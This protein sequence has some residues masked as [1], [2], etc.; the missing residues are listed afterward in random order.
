MIAFDQLRQDIQQR[1]RILT[2]LECAP[3][4]LCSQVGLGTGQKDSSTKQF[5]D[6]SP[7]V[8][9]TR[10]DTPLPV[11]AYCQQVNIYLS[12]IS[13]SHRFAVFLYI[14]LL[15]LR[16]VA[17]GTHN[18]VYVRFRISVGDTPE[19][20][21]DT[22]V[23]PPPSMRRGTNLG[24][25]SLHKARNLNDENFTLCRVAHSGPRCKNPVAKH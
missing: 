19:V 10:E 12:H 24:I 5:S 4:C 2:D 21:R 15:V 22:R 25:V 9:L 13:I 8:V 18:R 11:H 3:I 20:L 17:R 1:C 23:P 14:Q 6:L 16:R 7:W